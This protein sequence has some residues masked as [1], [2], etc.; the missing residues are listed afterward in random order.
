[1][2]RAKKEH[3]W[4]SLLSWL[5]DHENALLG[6]L[7][8]GKAS[9]T[10]C[11]GAH[12]SMGISLRLWNLHCLACSSQSISTSLWALVGSSFAKWSGW[13]N[14][15]FWCCHAIAK[16]CPTLQPHGLQPQAPLSATIT[17]SLLEFTSI[18]SVMLSNHL[19]LGHPLLLLPSI[20]PCIRVF[21]SELVFLR[22]EN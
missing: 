10:W 11:I 3:Q 13:W 4:A 17:R 5:N 8:K 1:M 12:C 14:E 22:N 19:T 2:T 21:S 7:V 16:S 9:Q 6:V 20:F 15:C 18:E